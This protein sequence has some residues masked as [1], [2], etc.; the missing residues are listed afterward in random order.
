MPRGSKVDKVYRGILKKTGDKG[1]AARIA[2]SQTGQ[3]L[4]TGKPP[5]H[6]KESQARR[7]RLQHQHI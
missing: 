6:S 3:A 7:K 1:K 5:K 4:A 2:Q